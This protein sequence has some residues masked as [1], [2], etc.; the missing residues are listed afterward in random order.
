MEC[1]RGDANIGRGGG[2][3]DLGDGSKAIICKTAPASVG[4]SISTWYA[5]LSWISAMNLARCRLSCDVLFLVELA[6]WP[7]QNVRASYFGVKSE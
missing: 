1:S 3:R 6:W 5:T 7:S 4:S 2:S